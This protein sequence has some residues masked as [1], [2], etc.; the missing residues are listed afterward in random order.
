MKILF[1]VNVAWFLIS[2]RLE[3]ARAARDNGFDVHV[4]A[5]V[6][7]AEERETLER[8]GFIFHR[9]RVRRGG[10]SPLHDLAYFKE[11]SGVVRR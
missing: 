4:A 1:N 11:L 7:S 9:I 10:L 2:H 8:E 3:I 5:D 6:E